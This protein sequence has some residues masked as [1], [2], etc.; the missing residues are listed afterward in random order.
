MKFMI[1]ENWTMV[2]IKDYVCTIVQ[3]EEDGKMEV[4]VYNSKPTSEI[5][6]EGPCAYGHIAFELIDINSTNI[7]DSVNHCINNV[8]ETLAYVA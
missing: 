6:I 7:I 3:N 4:R 5:E 1:F 8:E 2:E